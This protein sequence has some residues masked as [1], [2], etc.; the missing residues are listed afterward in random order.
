LSWYRENKD[1]QQLL[2]I[3]SVYMGHKYLAHTS[4]YLSMT[5][6]LLREAN[7]RFEKYAKTRKS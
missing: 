3:L 5:D 7:N 4:I 1:V 6:N 2:P